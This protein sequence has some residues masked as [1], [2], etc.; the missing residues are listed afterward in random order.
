MKAVKHRDPEKTRSEILR[1][2]Y[3]EVYRRGFRATSVDDILART[4][5]T[6]GAF[7][8]HFPSKNDVGYAL[9]DEVL[10]E[11]TLDRWIRPLAAYRNPV[12]GMERRFRALMQETPDEDLAFGCPLN[13]LTQEMS[14]I[15]PVFRDKLRAILWMWIGATE[16][17]LRRAQADGFVKPGVDVRA[18]AEFVVMAEEGSAALVKNLTDRRVYRSLYGGF[19]MFL[20]SISTKPL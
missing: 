15:D 6:K 3:G 16:G 10:R 18:A 9:A 4:G 13:N 19:R 12:K 2:A 17:Q 5:V 20:E 14:P 7:F 1:A 11:M 8:H